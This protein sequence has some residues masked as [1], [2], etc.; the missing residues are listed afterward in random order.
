MLLWVFA[1]VITMGVLKLGK[2]ETK[3]TRLA[4]GSLVVTTVVTLISIP[5]LVLLG[6]TDMVTDLNNVLSLVAA[7]LLSAWFFI[8]RSK[9]SM[10]AI[11]VYFVCQIVGTAMMLPS[12]P[13]ELWLGT[14]AGGVVAVVGLLSG[15]YCLWTW[16]TSVLNEVQVL[17]SVFE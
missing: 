17:K 8:A 14:A 13:P 2:I 5:I 9:L 15:I 16:S 10:V 12:L 11:C 4:V 1:I 3:P 6:H 7:L